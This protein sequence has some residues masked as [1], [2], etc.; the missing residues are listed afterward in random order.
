MSTLSASGSMPLTAP[1]SRPWGR[2][3]SAAAA[4]LTV[5][6]FA[7][8]S[9]T[10][11]T[12]AE[13]TA[14]LVDDQVTLTVGALLAVLVAA[15]LLVAAVRLGRSVSGDTGSVIVA[16]GCA[17]AVLYAA[18][19]S[20]FGAGAV[21]ATQTLAAPGPGLGEAASL[22][23]NIAEITRFAP[24]LALVAAGVVARRELPRGVGISA[25]MLA[26]MT[27]APMTSWVA[28][29]LIP[30]W[31]GIS[32]ARVSD[33]PGDGSDQPADLRGLASGA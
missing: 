11:D 2:L 8:T 24:G 17:V 25:A 19:Y 32:A 21:V 10:G 4:A 16:S 9:L 22:L 1:A 31:L 27:L 28:A 13:I 18:F 6:V 20:V 5:P 14:G 33:R 29:L 3:A 7:L 30:A 12:G 15:G 23:L 26:V